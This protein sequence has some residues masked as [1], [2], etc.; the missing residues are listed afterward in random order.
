M[1][2][3]G[4]RQY[5]Y[6]IILFSIECKTN[7]IPILMHQMR[8]S[9]IDAQVENFGNQKKRW[10]LKEP[11]DENHTDIIQGFAHTFRVRNLFSITWIILIWNIAAIFT[12]YRSWILSTASSKSYKGL[13]SVLWNCITVSYVYDIYNFVIKKHNQMKYE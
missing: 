3:V 9:T 12:F 11:S 6:L 13:S 5:H 10:K 7:T 2:S 8:I 1:Y 4:F